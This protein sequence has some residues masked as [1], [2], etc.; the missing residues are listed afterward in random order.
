M[1]EPSFHL[2]RET[3]A[4]FRTTLSSVNKTSEHQLSPTGTVS[5]HPARG[6][7]E[8]LGQHILS[9]SRAPSS[10][11]PSA[12][13]SLVWGFH[14]HD[15]NSYSRHCAFFFFLTL[16]LFIYL[17]MAVLGLRFCARAFSSCGK[18]GSLFITVRGSLTIAASLVVEHRLQTHRLSSCGSRAQLLRGTWDPPR[19]G[20]EPV[21]PA[22]AGRP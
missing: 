10:L 20:L 22:L 19:P 21:S 18:R 15:Q 16:G 13:P 9:D 11:C 4:A 17:F 14:F 6:P 7:R 8:R 3:R 12:L 5:C 2:K 1:S